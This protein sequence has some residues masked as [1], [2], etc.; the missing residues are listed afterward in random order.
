M[1]ETTAPQEAKHGPIASFRE[2]DDVHASIFA[3]QHKGKTYYSW[4]ISRFYRDAAGKPSYTH[5]L[6]ADSCGAVASLAQKVSEKIY[7]LDTGK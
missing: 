5:S 3:R 7:E 6:N 2:G 1:E 4:V